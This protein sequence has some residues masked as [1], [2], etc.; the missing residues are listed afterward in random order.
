MNLFEQA[1][2]KDELLQFALGKD[3]YFL[4]DRD[5]GDHSV[6]NSWTTSVLPL[7]E[8]R[9]LE[10]VNDKIE[11]MFRVLIN[12]DLDAQI[13]NESILYHLHVY[14]YLNGEGRIRACKMTSI[15]SQ[16]L[17]SLNLYIDCLKNN[18]DSKENA[19]RNALSLIQSRGGL[20]IE[21]T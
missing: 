13:K 20:T 12:S 16:L 21:P 5:Y 2:A 14:Y 8:K 6:I 1:I 7:I 4:A 9:G 11:E 17:F 18:N 10:F 15:N 19:I 3:E